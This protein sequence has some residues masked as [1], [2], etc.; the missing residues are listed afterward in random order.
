MKKWNEIIMEENEKSW[1]NIAM[2]PNNFEDMLMRLGLL[3]RADGKPGLKDDSEY[4]DKK[5]TGKIFIWNDK[6]S[7]IELHTTSNP[8]TGQGGKK[9]FLGS[10][11]VSGNNSRIREAE[12]MIISMRK[13]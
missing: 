6:N 5:P 7:D 13:K 1:E 12:A 4:K 10:V 11:I 8:W 3:K 2:T 9:G